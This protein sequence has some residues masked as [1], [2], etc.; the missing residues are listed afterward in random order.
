MTK[1]T[2]TKRKFKRTH[3]SFSNLT[4][5]KLNWLEYVT[6]GIGMWFLFYPHPYKWVFTL[7]LC[8]PILGLVLNGLTGRPS[9]ASLVEVSLDKDGTDKYDVA[10]FIDIA[11]WIILLR[12]LLDFE[13][14]NVYSL[15]IPGA[16][17]FI[18]LLILLMVT[19]RLIDHSTKSKAWIYCS[20][21]F[22]VFLYSI[23]ATYAANCVYDESPPQ[24]YDVKVVDKRI[25]TS[26]KGR[27]TYYFKVTPW[28]HHYDKEEISVTEEQYNQIDR[29]QTVMVDLKEGL[30]GI[31]WYYI[32]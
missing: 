29:G 8:M 21:I 22:N 27:K 18:L 10:D 20:L 15:I 4:F 30:F 1:P 11:A 26:S 9:I 17:G 32:E 28:G 13:F 19:H 3:V 25:T 14:D 23:G 2:Q 24:V 5:H 12:V 6:L 31:A 7:L 16:V